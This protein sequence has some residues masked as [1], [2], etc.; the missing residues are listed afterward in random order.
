MTLNQ[1]GRPSAD[2]SDGNWTTSSGSGS[3]ASHINEGG[4]PNDSNY[5][6]SGASPSNDEAVVSL[7]PID[8]PQ[9]GTVTIRI[10]VK[11]T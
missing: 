8:T 6:R 4:A 3:L 10:R 5:I 9:A 1:W 2:V 11:H 7:N